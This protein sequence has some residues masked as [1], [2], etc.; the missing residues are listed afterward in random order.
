MTRLHSVVSSFLGQ[1]RLK[2]ELA[3][4]SILFLM[5]TLTS[6]RYGWHRDELYFV[7]AGQHPAWGYPDQPLLTPLVTAALNYLG[8]GSLVVVRLASALASAATTVLV[9]VIA[10]QL[11][12]STRARLIASAA[13][14]VGAVSLVTGHFVDTTT[15]DILATVGVC[16]SLI[17]AIR[18]NSGRWIMMAGAVLGLGLL[19]KMIVGAVIALVCV[20]LVAVGPR[21]ILLSRYSLAAAGFAALGAAPYLVWQ[22]L[23]GWPQVA[24]AHS[25]AAGGAEGGRIGVIPFQLL[26][27]SPFLVPVWVA[28]IILLLRNRTAVPARAFAV[29]YL[30]LVVALIVTG[31]K[32]YYA[33]GLLPVMV[34]AGGVAA[35]AWLARARK[36][37]SLRGKVAMV[38][39]AVVL[40]FVV[41]AAIGLAILPV[42]LLTPTAVER[43]NPDAGEQ[44]AWLAFTTAVARAFATIPAS[45]R[46][47]TVILTNNYGEAGAVDKYG[48]AL[49]LP[50]AFSG[51]N[52]FAFWG[53]PTLEGPVVLVGFDTSPATE[54]LFTNCHVATKVDNGVNLNNQEQG[55][56]IQVCATP[57]RPWAKLWPKLV[58]FN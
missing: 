5:L 39:T 32:A 6:S 40:A 24:L 54:R 26:L 37:W 44:V 41:N 20:C 47:S 14:A 46:A 56:L 12:G 53:P 30:V 25:I 34:A 35:D 45:Q 50:Q 9:G 52:G 2:P 33:A 7:V 58:H 31:G 27:V 15:F 48:H 51:H 13:W 29:A 42:N 38:S 57:A 22:A 55:T 18:N 43:I 8:S 10:G 3:V 11:G 23:H 49:G 4:A 17:A 36:R 19:D 1:V 16:S 21:S 28:G